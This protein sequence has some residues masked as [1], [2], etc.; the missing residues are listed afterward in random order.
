MLFVTTMLFSYLPVFVDLNYMILGQL[1]PLLLKLILFWM[2]ANI[3]QLHDWQFTETVSWQL[4][5]TGLR[6]K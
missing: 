1:I 2:A 6:L 3:S 5:D 4:A